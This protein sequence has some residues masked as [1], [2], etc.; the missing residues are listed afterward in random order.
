[1]NL[2]L[3]FESLDE[4]EDFFLKKLDCFLKNRL[5]F[6]LDEPNKALNKPKNII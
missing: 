5:R 4:I 6:F 3:K 1:M 2:G